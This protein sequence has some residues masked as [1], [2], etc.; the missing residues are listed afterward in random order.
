MGQ[1]RVAVLEDGDVTVHDNTTDDLSIEARMALAMADQEVVSG[2][3]PL[4]RT[5]AEC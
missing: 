5:Q 2:S 4:H 1:N 3:C